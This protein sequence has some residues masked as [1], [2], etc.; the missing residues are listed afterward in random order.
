MNYLTEI[1]A[2]SLA[3]WLGSLFFVVFLKICVAPG[4]LKRSSF[5]YTTFLFSVL[6]IFHVWIEIGL[7]GLYAKDFYP[8][9]MAHVW[10][11]A[12]AL[13]DF[14]VVA[15]SLYLHRKLSL[16]RSY[17]SIMFMVC[18]SLMGVMQMAR[19][20]DRMIFETDY[21][22]SVYRNG[23]PAINSIITIVV[24]WHAALIIYQLL[25][26]LCNDAW[27]GIQDWAKSFRQVIK[28]FWV[29]ITPFINRG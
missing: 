21:L 5:E 17:S 8:L 20:A 25:W 3:I 29:T 10:Y 2:G 13:T 11:F 12:F 19:Y 4:S 23:I 6:S 18:F 27:S 15:L 24:V 22:D 7:L 1:S 28:K 26:P 14:M 16:V 9:F